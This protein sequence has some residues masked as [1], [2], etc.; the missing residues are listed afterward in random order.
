VRTMAQNQQSDPTRSAATPGGDFDQL[1][2][3]SMPFA[4]ANVWNE[5]GKQRKAPK[6][7]LVPQGHT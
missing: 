4:P 1:P 5:Q 3:A 2:Y 7:S 6:R